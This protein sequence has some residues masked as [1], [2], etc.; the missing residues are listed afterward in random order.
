MTARPRPSPPSARRAAASAVAAILVSAAAAGATQAAPVPLPQAPGGMAPPTAAPP[1]TTEAASAPAGPTMSFEDAVRAGRRALD[2]NDNDAA[3]AAYD[4]ALQARPDSAEAAFNRGVA[5]YR[6]GRF[7]EAIDAFKGSGE[8]ASTGERTDA[9]LESS[10]KFNRAASFYGATKAQAEAAQ[11]MLEQAREREAAGD[12]PSD[13]PT[14]PA[15]DPEQLKQAIDDARQSFE[16]FRDASYGDAADLDSRANAEQARRLVRALQELQQQQ[17]QQQSKQGQDRKQD[18]QQNQ[19]QQNQ[20]QQNQ[21]QQQQDSDQQK[22]DQQGAEPQDQQP[23]RDETPKADEGQDGR[24]KDEP[25]GQ[26]PKQDEPKQEQGAQEDGKQ[27]ERQQEPKQDGQQQ[28]AESRRA[29]GE[30][31]KDEADR[32]L[33]GVRD[34]ERRRRTEQQRREQEQ[35][36][37]GRKPIKDW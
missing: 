17:Q 8:K 1:P 3:V 32:L 36:A 16:N 5:L 15:V 26:E 6:A 21:D 9:A 22:P 12:G 33:Q 29:N 4:A 25:Q 30:M 35:A 19:D 7:K 27:E 34:R 23:K 14:A 37:R 10:S 11:R 2:A 28:P 13:A 20:D 18:Q 24:Q 31:T